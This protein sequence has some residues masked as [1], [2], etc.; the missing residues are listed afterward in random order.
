MVPNHKYIIEI[1]WGNKSNLSLLIEVISFLYVQ[2][3][4]KIDTHTTNTYL[5]AKEMF[6]NH[7]PA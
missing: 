5:K 2:G 3:N 7:Q 1:L 4:I 6:I